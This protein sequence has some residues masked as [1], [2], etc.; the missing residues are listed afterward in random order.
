MV[1]DDLLRRS[2][3]EFLGVFTFVFISAGAL[4][5]EAMVGEQSLI[6]V[7][8]AGGLAFAIMVSALGHIS[9]G[10][11]NPAITLGFLVT[12]KIRLETAASYWTSQL[13]GSVLAALLLRAVF[14]DEFVDATNLGAPSLS[15]GVSIGEGFLL[16]V[17]LTFLLVLVVF[18][19][20][21]HPRGPFT[22]VAGFAIGLTITVGILVGGPL[23]GAAMNPARAFGPELVAGFWSDG[24]LYYLAPLVGGAVA[25][26]LYDRAFLEPREAAA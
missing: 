23:T 14:N 4:V 13:A 6:S 22:I 3:A 9:G 20:M 1:P 25:A 11:F 5:T 21:V 16:E 19:T 12:G 2:L 7:A 8:I 18:A 17:I 15:E 24:W 10:H 26:V